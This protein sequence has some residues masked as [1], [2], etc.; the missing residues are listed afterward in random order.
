[1]AVC[2]DDA[3]DGVAV[4]HAIAHLPDRAFIVLPNDDRMWSVE[5]LCG[6][7]GSKRQLLSRDMF[8]ARRLSVI[9]P[10][11]PSTALANSAVRAAPRT[12]IARALSLR[13]DQAVSL[14]HS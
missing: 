14:S 7:Q 1:M 11:G 8:V 9:D 4:A 6:R 5:V 3:S 12:H 10:S 2:A 13:A